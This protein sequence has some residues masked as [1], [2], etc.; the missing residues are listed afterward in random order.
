[1]SAQTELLDPARKSDPS[2]QDE[3]HMRMKEL[4]RRGGAPVLVAAV[5]AG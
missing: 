2:W 4:N 1:M 5:D 3:Y